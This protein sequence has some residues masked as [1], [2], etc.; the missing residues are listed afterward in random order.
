[1]IYKKYHFEQEDKFNNLN[2]LFPVKESVVENTYFK[3]KTFLKYANR[4]I[5]GVASLFDK[6]QLNGLESFKKEN[7]IAYENHKIQINER[8]AE[9]ESCKNNS[10]EKELFEMSKTERAC[11]IKT[12]AKK[13]STFIDLRCISGENDVYQKLIEKFG[14]E[15]SERLSS[16]KDS[17]LIQVL[18]Y[19]VM[20][21]IYFYENTALLYSKITFFKFSFLLFINF[22]NSK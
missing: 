7:A 3:T 8:L 19:K 4:K 10:L 6:E 5:F 16:S 13:W 1:M 2:R 15:Y 12:I 22:L 14:Y 17:V 11:F 20:V 21:T 9:I 18:W